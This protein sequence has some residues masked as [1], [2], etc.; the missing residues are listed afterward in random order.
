MDRTQLLRIVA[1]AMSDACAAAG[2]A[3]VK[4]DLKAPQYG[5]MV[6]AVPASGGQSWCALAVVPACMLTVKPRLGLQTVC[7]KK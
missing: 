3:E 2:V 4:V 7:A 6:E 1:G 5:I